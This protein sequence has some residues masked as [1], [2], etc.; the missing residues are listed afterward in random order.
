MN[1]NRFII[2]NTYSQV[3]IAIQL[4][5]T[6]FLNDNV[7][8]LVSDKC[9][10]D[11]K[12][13]ADRLGTENAF[14]EVFHIK[15]FGEFENRN[16]KGKWK[17]IQECSNGKSELLQKELNKISVDE[18]IFFNFGFSTL[19]VYS[20]LYNFNVNM[21]ASRME[22]G[23]AVYNSYLMS[24]YENMKLT[25]KLMFRF[26]RLNRFF[27][28]KSILEK[29]I[30]QFYCYYPEL[31]KGKNKPIRIPLVNQNEIK[32]IVANVFGVTK[33]DCIIK[34]KYLFFA[35]IGDFEGEKAI[36]EKEIVSKIAE[37]VG[38]EN[39]IIKL[40]PRDTSGNFES[41]GLKIYKS[42]SIPWEAIQLN[43]DFS[44]HVFLSTTSS[45]VL[46][47]NMMLENKTKTIF[48]Y[49]LCDLSNNVPVQPAYNMLEKLFGKNQKDSEIFVADTLEDII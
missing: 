44:N 21:E 1:K 47:V 42:S 48:L 23:V 27:Q 34:E 36:G 38:K 9:S 26:I 5:K 10:K 30:K 31:Y 7:Y 17:L 46:G 11:S 29:S 3:I 40:H 37:L 20:Y 43:G 39:L 45:S 28:G 18:L 49:R 16:I 19:A 13:V 32:E 8:V 4:K 15:L 24:Y 33:E 22:E 35:G 6:L 2:C 14:N 12:K 25:R 41:T